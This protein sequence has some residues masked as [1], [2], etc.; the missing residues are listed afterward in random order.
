M[1]TETITGTTS[2]AA[3]TRVKRGLA[4]ML[5]GGVIM[6]VVT[7]EQARIA[8]DA[9]ASA[10]M[11]LERVPADI[12]AQGGVARMSDPDLIAG[13]VDAVSIPVMA[14]AR[15]GHFV[16][17][18]VLQSL[19]VDYIDE[20][21][22]LSPADYTNHIDKWAFDVPFVC[23]A[24][25]LG[26]ALRRITEGAAMIRSKGEAGT[27]DVSEAVKH[28]RT[29][30]GQ[31]NRLRSMDADE[32]YVSAKELSA[33]FDLVREVAETG[34]LPVVLFVA[35]GVATPADAALVMQM[36]AEGVFVGSGI[37][38]SGNPA[39]RAAAIVKATTFYDD[40]ATI[41]E[42][43]RGLGEAMVGINVSD[44][45]APHRLAERGW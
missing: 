38:K 16:E 44:V 25:N 27:G 37:F 26:E 7:P 28:L 35:G 18:Q 31:I 3:T 22:V 14:K 41:A 15:I 23:G 12:R 21:E 42:V 36:G 24:T 8:E 30:R 2:T 20:S 39:A 5:K 19:K 34:K 32:L 40:P 13:I 29:I 4:D 1:A 45:A 17:A 10:V 11:A 9:G 6:D 43:S 33:P